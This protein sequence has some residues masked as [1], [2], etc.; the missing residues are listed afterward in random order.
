MHAEPLHIDLQQAIDAGPFAPEKRVTT[1]CWLCVV[2][3]VIALV[4]GLVTE[5]PDAYVWG[6]YYTSFLFWMGLSVGS[7]MTTVIVQIVRATWVVPVRRIAEA[8]IAFLPWAFVL[9]LIT[10]LGK[11]HL[12]PWAV[13]PMPGREWWM[14]PGFVYMRFGLLFLLFFYLLYQYTKNSLRSDVGVAQEKAA[15]SDSW[16][17][18]I[19]A[20]LTESWRG[21]KEEVPALQRRMSI[22]A[23]AVV[24]AYVVVWTLFA[25]EMLA[26]MNT[27]WFS[28][29][30]GGFEFLGNIYMGWAAT[31]VI[32]IHLAAKNEV[33]SKIL[34]RRQ[35]WDLGMLCF[36]FCMLWG[37]TFFS[38]Y[39]PQWYGNMPEETQWL[40]LRTKE[41]PWKPFSYLTLATAF[42]I[43]F[44]L[45]LS[46]DVKK[47]PKTFMGVAGVIFTGLWLEKYVLIMPELSPSLV[48]FSIVDVG[49]FLGMMG[50]YGLSIQGFLRRFPIITVSHP[51]AKNDT[52]SW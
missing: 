20:N 24:V 12:F 26:G 46:E 19:Y 31:G 48:P 37:Y 10:Y 5:Y 47:N 23:P 11:E 36:G 3:G 28:N 2:F 41:F 27:I 43:P 29:M 9:F 22:M 40:I 39:L 15:N 17:G 16:K 52:T 35:L 4:G 33:F 44:I 51:Q 1:L 14:Q 34:R 6:T 18:G 49:I 7:V 32:A 13:T 50:I 21:E 8:N 38:Q 45:L 42:I 30:F 25:T